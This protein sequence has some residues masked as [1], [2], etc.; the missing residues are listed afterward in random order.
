MRAREVWLILLAGVGSIAGC[1]SDEAPA[2]DEGADA[3]SPA[4]MWSELPSVPTPR[5]EV[6]AVVLAGELVV[7]GGFTAGSMA[8]N[9]AEALNLSIGAWRDLPPM[10]VP[11]HHA[12]AVAHG[13]L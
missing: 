5:T 8:S 12:P 3:R 13:G 9:A 2:P 4:W 7:L 11:L 1:A 10:P 6:A